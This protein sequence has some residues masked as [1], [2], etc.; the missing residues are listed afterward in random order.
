MSKIPT[1]QQGC[2]I[3]YTISSNNFNILEIEVSR[4]V[5]TAAV[6]IFHWETFLNVSRVISWKINVACFSKL[7]AFS[8]RSYF[9][10]RVTWNA[11]IYFFRSTYLINHREPVVQI[12][13]YVYR[14]D[15]TQWL[16]MFASIAVPWNSWLKE[17]FNLRFPE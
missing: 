11:L 12:C 8:C 9:L 14:T 2:W 10:H 13:M 1:L 7:S 15:I 4:S 6:K 17:T 16:N 5:L 3:F